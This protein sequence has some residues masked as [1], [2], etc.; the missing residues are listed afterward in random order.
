MQ[1]EI[2]FEGQRGVCDVI[3]VGQALITA[4][5]LEVVCAMNEITFNW[6]NTLIKL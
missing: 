2:R 3:A 1:I 6:N 5:A 4:H